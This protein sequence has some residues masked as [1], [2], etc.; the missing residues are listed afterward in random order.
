MLAMIPIPLRAATLAGL[1]LTLSGCS[2]KRMAI[3][4]LGDA[5]ASGSSS[6]FARDDDPE[7]VRDAT[8]FALKT[9]ESLI[10][11][12]PRHQ[13]L[14]TA[15]VSGFTQYGYAFVQQEA[16]FTEAADL[17]RATQLRQRAKRLYLRAAEYG[18]RGIEVDV[19]QFRDRLSTDADA[20]L[21][22]LSAKHV[23]LLYWTAA[24]WAAALAIDVNDPDLSTKQTSIEKMMHRALALDETFEQGALHDFF[25]TWEAAH[26]STGSSMA[27]ARE[28]FNR[29]L[30]LSAGRRAAPYVT[31]AEAV[32]INENNKKEFDALLK[33]ALAVDLQK[34]PNQ[35]LANVV[36]QRRAKWL[37]GRIDDL[38][39]D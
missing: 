28:H 33:A 38:F 29:A 7:L 4:S 25:I 20:T 17:D 9:I 22:K 31:M 16:D 1:A 30:E 35:R 26:A 14:L 2:I 39:V 12:S 37:L 8:P 24:A 5:L 34:D 13:G 6:T 36:N 10:D 11:A 19:P 23:P 15:A 3:N 21:S 18:L 27:K 32:S